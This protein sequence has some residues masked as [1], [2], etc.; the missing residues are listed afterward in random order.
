MHQCVTFVLW[1]VLL[2]IRGDDVR[3][4]YLKL[5]PFLHE[6]DNVTKRLCVKGL[7]KKCD[8]FDLTFFFVYLRRTQTHTL[9]VQYDI[10]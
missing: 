4:W 3:A 7:I 8:L 6:D 1:K 2:F 10:L 5:S 9:I